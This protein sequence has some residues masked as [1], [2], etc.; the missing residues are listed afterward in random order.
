M[1]IL[2]KINVK[3]TFEA[4]EKCYLLKPEMFYKLLKN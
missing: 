4:V 2:K 3:K 1:V